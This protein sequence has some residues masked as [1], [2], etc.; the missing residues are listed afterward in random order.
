M[1]AGDNGPSL[2]GN[3]NAFLDNQAEGVT[4]SLSELLKAGL[5]G[6][7]AGAS[8]DLGENAREL[9]EKLLPW[10]Q[11]HAAEGVQQYAKSLADAGTPRV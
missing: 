8:V 3:N 6:E 2:P 11:K 9:F 10:L 5:S 1:Q 7:L 4:E